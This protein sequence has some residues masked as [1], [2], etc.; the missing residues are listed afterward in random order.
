[1]RFRYS[2]VVCI[3][4]C[5][6]LPALHSTGCEQLSHPRTFQWERHDR[7]LKQPV[8]CL[9]LSVGFPYS[10]CIWDPTICA[11]QCLTPYYL[12]YHV[13]NSSLLLQELV[14]HSLLLR[15]S[16]SLYEFTKCVYPFSQTR[17]N[18]YDLALQ[19]RYSAKRLPRLTHFTLT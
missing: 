19:T 8:F 12:I 2:E 16:V 7:L 3:W 11:L 5:M 14:I 18:L 1:M 10:L 6:V 13:H 4:Y 9:L 15:C 17:T